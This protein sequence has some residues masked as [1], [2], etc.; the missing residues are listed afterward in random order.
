MKKATIRSNDATIIHKDETLP[1]NINIDYNELYK[2]LNYERHLDGSD[3][4]L[5]IRSD[6]YIS[7]LRWM[8]DGSPGNTIRLGVLREDRSCVDLNKAISFDKKGNIQIPKLP[9]HIQALSSQEMS[10]IKTIIERIT[11]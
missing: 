10:A 6:L 7:P 8:D 2:D 3:V 9:S 5:L 11:K 1:D 4:V